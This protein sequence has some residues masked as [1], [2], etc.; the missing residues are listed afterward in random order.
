MMKVETIAKSLEEYNNLQK[1][2]DEFEEA[3]KNLQKVKK[4]SSYAEGGIVNFE[5]TFASAICKNI[6][7]SNNATKFIKYDLITI[8]QDKVKELK[9]KQ[10]S[11]E[12]E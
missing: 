10:A 5:M 8:F 7:L 9:S 12:I 6:H 4:E 2:I 1:L 11:L 3:E